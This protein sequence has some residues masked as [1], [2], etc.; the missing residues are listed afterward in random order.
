MY[1]T[2]DVDAWLLLLDSNGDSL[3]SNTYSSLEGGGN[4][5]AYSVVQVE[6]GSFVFCGF[7]N[8]YP[9]VAKTEYAEPLVVDPC[10]LGVVFISEAHNSE[11]LRII[12]KFTIKRFRL[13]FRRIST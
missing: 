9:F 11:T 6:D 10:E 2:G 7:Y 5:K 3:W 1:E 8:D 13:F 12:L 4:D